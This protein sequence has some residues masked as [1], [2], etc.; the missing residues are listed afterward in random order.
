MPS[1]AKIAK[2]FSEAEARRSRCFTTLMP[3]KECCRDIFVGHALIT[4]GLEGPELV[5]RVQR[6]ALDI[7]RE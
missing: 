4:Q 3:T 1:S 7:F 5:E 2:Q 6:H